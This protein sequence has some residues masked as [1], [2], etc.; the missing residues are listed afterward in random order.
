MVVNSANNMNVSFNLGFSR[1][2]FFFRL[3][4]NSLS[5]TLSTT[6]SWVT[7]VAYLTFVRYIKHPRQHSYL[8]RLYP[9]FITCCCCTRFYN[10]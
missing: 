5:N 7:L 2:V 6:S 10:T 3:S 8:S 1:P 4:V 9:S